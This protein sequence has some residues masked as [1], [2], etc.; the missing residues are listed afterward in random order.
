MSI[1]MT[2]EFASAMVTV[3][4]VV[5]LVATVEYHEL[6]RRVSEETKSRV[7][8]AVEAGTDGP[9]VVRDVLNSPLIKG[10]KNVQAAWY[11]VLTLHVLAEMYLIFWLADDKRP[12]DPPFALYVAS[13]GCLGFLM[14]V[15]GVVSM[16]LLKSRETRRR[17]HA[18]HVQLVRDQARQT[19]GESMD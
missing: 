7:A 9:Q 5:L 16:T 3:I 13:I 1:K 12:G 2:E 17:L 6:S 15:A 8:E 18:L 10:L 4:P 14:V 11:G 19:A